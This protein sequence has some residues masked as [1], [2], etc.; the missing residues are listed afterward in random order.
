MW[1]LIYDGKTLKTTKLYNKNCYIYN[2]T[3]YIQLLY[4]YNL[5][6]YNNVSMK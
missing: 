2:Y 1:S 6:I 5:C 3:G 4:M